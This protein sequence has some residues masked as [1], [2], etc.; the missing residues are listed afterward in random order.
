MAI[1][2]TILPRTEG[3]GLTRESWLELMATDARLAPMPKRRVPN[4]FKPGEVM[5]YGGL[6]DWAVLV[7]DGKEL[8]S[9]IWSGSPRPSL[10]AECALRENETP[11]LFVLNQLADK[12]ACLVEFPGYREG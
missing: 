1:S 8:G 2:W 5:D 11:M 7:V 10:L 3:L 6:P 9:V 4:P 12:I